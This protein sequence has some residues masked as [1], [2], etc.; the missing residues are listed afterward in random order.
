[1]EEYTCYFNKNSA[2][3]P[4]VLFLSAFIDEYIFKLHFERINIVKNI[5]K[6][7]E[8]I[9]YI[10]KNWDHADFIMSFKLDNTIKNLDVDYKKPNVFERYISVKPSIFNK[11]I[12][13]GS[14]IKNVDKPG[15]DVIINTTKTLKEYAVKKGNL[16][17]ISFDNL[18]KKPFY[19]WELPNDLYEKYN[20]LTELYNYNKIPNYNNEGL[21]EY[22]KI[23]NEHLI[24][25]YQEE[26]NLTPKICFI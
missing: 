1:M 25:T 15:A 23:V 20:R 12:G 4:K 22:S 10:N 13:I 3:A 11:D 2:N 14:I 6:T 18:F 8:S 24:P 7:N 21:E 9:E 5:I 19:K 17:I 26:F 16:Y